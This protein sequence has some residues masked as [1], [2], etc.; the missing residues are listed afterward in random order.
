MYSLKSSGD[1]PNLQVV[2]QTDTS[3]V[4]RFLESVASSSVVAVLAKLPAVKLTEHT[5]DCNAQSGSRWRA[6]R[7]QFDTITDSSVQFRA[8]GDRDLCTFSALQNFRGLHD[9]GRKR[10]IANCPRWRTPKSAGRTRR[11]CSGRDMSALGLV[12]ASSSFQGHFS[13]PDNRGE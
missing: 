11:S 13:V 4:V 3:F 7:S 5:L 2:I 10:R 6:A 1:R 8:S 9:R 12:H